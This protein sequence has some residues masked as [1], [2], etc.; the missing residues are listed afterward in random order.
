MTRVGKFRPYIIFGAIPL[1]ALSAVVFYV[2][3]SLETSTKLLYAYITYAALGFVYSLVNIAYG[4]LASAVTQSVGER[5]KLVAGRAFGAALGGI[6]LTYVVGTMVNDL[7][8]QK[9][10][11]T[12]PEAL[13]AYQDA[14]QGVFLKVTL[15]FVV[16]GTL[17]FWFCAWAVP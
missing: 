14:V 15:A 12:T 16:V 3:A 7:R 5:A 8:A 4:S 6:V 9:A 1:L 17:A 11:I 2:P 10:A 13:I